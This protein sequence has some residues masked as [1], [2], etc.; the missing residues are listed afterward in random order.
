MS[1]ATLADLA[2]CHPSFIGK[3]AT[4]GT[5]T[6]TRVLAERIAEALGVPLSSLFTPDTPTSSRPGMDSGDP[7]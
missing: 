3:L 6:V 1:Q 2:G 5:A 4:G 7:K